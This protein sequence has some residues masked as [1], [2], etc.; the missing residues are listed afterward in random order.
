VATLLLS[1]SALIAAL[2]GVV[3]FAAVELTHRFG[4]L[5]GP[6]H[7]I[8]GLFALA[9]AIILLARSASTPADSMLIGLVS[10]ASADSIAMADRLL[11]DS[12]WI[13]SGAGTY[14]TLIPIY[15][16]LGRPPPTGAPSLALK[17]AIEWGRASPALLSLCAL[18]AANTLVG[19][20]ML[21]GRDSFYPA[22][23]AACLA[24]LTFQAYGDASLLNPAPGLL[25]AIIVGLALAQ[26]AGR[27]TRG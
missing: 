1:S 2:L 4:L 15:E 23:A 10:S 27:S 13:G 25:S 6:H 8:V 3:T 19:A 20:A 5:K 24:I 16:E 17:L 26:A 12:T 14:A 18:F 21:R 11:K 22:A 9:A 7:V